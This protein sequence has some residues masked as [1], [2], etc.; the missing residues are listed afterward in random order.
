MESRLA[1]WGREFTTNIRAHHILGTV[2]VVASSLAALSIEAFYVSRIS[3]VAAGMV[4]G[5][6]GF[7]KP[8]QG[9]VKFVSAWRVLESAATRYRYGLT[10]LEQLLA[11]KDRG[12]EIIAGFERSAAAPRFDTERPPNTPPNTV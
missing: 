12:E 2:G 10:T 5:W 3:A 1:T 7:T 9:Y 4:F 11:A 8:E 6:M